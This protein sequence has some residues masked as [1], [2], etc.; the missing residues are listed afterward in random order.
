MKGDTLRLLCSRLR[1]HLAI[2]ERCLPVLYIIVAHKILESLPCD[3]IKSE[4]SYATS[5]PEQFLRNSPGTPWFC[6]K[7]LLDF[8]YQEYFST[9]SN[10]MKPKSLSLVYL[11]TSSLKKHFDNFE[12]FLDEMRFWFNRIW[13]YRYN[14][15]KNFKNTVT[16]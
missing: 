10:Y 7:F 1:R 15:I 16:K 9:L 2:R 14:R 8:F 11:N 3:Q 12:C 5:S 4:L 13:F 6:G